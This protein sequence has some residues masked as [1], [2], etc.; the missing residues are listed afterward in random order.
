MTEVV[1]TGIGI[2]EERQQMLFE[3]FLELQK[4]QNLDLVK[5]HNI[6]MGLSCSKVIVEGMGGSIKLSKSNEGMTIFEFRL[7]IESIE[8]EE[9]TQP[10]RNSKSQITEI[11]TI[12]QE[13]TIQRNAQLLSYLKSKRLNSLHKVNYV[14]DIN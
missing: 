5:D 1:D 8:D 12:E 2:S 7:P 9:L 6:G 14:C 4:K 13:A 10:V 11:T 3:P